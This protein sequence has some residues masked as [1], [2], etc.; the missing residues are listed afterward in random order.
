[1][2]QK[3]DWSLAFLKANPFDFTALP[4]AKHVT[5]EGMKKLD[6]QFSKI[7]REAT[8]SSHPQVVL[9]RAPRAEGQAYASSRFKYQGALPPF[10]SEGERFRAIHLR[11]PMQIEDAVNDFYTDFLDTLGMTRV[12][13]IVSDAIGELP[14]AEAWET[15]HKVLGGEELAR[16]FWLLG[17]EESDA[18][19]TLLR[20]YF[21]EGSSRTELR[22]LGIARNIKRQD[23][24][25]VLAGVIQC[26]IGLAPSLDIH[27]HA[28]VCLW[29]D[30]LE[31]L[32]C[33]D[34]VPFRELTQGI[35]DLIDRLP[36]FFTVFLRTDLVCSRVYRNVITLVLG[37]GLPER[38]TDVIYFQG[39]TV[40]EAMHYV[41]ERLNHRKYRLQTPRLETLPQTYPF[42]EEA[43]RVLLEDLELRTTGNIHKQCGNVLNA[44]FHDNLFLQ[45][46]GGIINQEYVEK[47]EKSVIVPDDG[48][49]I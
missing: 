21:L 13:E 8:L 43:L 41:T 16:A 14:K 47:L 6:R 36:H 19:Q 32:L 4:G 15:L 22:E 20:N 49:E 27:R 33:V 35:R 10:F 18:K 42:K 30:E 12:R 23:R 48:R 7:L 31:N 45:A 40:D 38:I 44:A 46:G 9:F 3:W 29:I 17:T 5:C 2:F 37:R 39:L 25:R 1:M 24:F 28:R 26:L 11:V 34:R